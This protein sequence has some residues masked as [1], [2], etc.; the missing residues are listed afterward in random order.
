MKLKER[1]RI[2]AKDKQLRIRTYA[3]LG[4]IYNIVWSV[5]KLLI[6]IVSGAFFFA[7]S[8]IH[9]L[10]TGIIKSVFFKNYRKADGVREVKASRAMG[11]LTMISAV[12][13]TAYMARL[14]FVSDDSSYGE[15]TSIAIAA[16]AFGELG[17][18]IGGFVKSR[19]KEDLMLSALKGSKMAS[20]F[21][22][23]VL[24]QTAILS[25][26]GNTGVG[27][28]NALSGVIFGFCAFVVGAGVLIYTYTADGIVKAVNAP[29]DKDEACAEDN[30]T[31]KAD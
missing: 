12:A 17:M 19:K 8:G 30:L 23:I 3:L 6:G 11:I 14:F 24:T 29:D 27:P 1:M 20:G 31:Q 10:F 5:A 16:F 13:F 4:M 26:K 21:Y 18:S 25:A 9:T 7:I 2:F 15:I 28:F 22:A